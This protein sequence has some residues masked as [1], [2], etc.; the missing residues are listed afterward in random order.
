MSDADKELQGFKDLLSDPILGEKFIQMTSTPEGYYNMYGDTRGLGSF[1]VRL[2]QNFEPEDLA[3]RYTERLDSVQNARSELTSTIVQKV[4]SLDQKHVSYLQRALA[5]GPN[6]GDDRHLVPEPSSYL[7]EPTISEAL[8]K[9]TSNAEDAYGELLFW[10]KETDNFGPLLS[11][12]QISNDPRLADRF[13]HYYHTPIHYSDM[14]IG[15][16][17]ED[18]AMQDYERKQFLNAFDDYCKLESQREIV[19]QGKSSE[20]G[21]IV[22]L[23]LAVKSVLK[24]GEG[25]RK[26]EL[27]AQ[28]SHVRH[29]P[30]VELQLLKQLVDK[31]AI[32]KGDISVTP[33]SNSAG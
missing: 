6:G 18:D 23:V 7:S 30:A 14:Y 12:L 13:L 3:D 31:T 4:D 19:R 16:G 33:D 5:P 10:G 11:L 22:S 2:V 1:S 28:I 21:V 25:R 15:G 26:R 24:I 9:Y 20:T 17:Y 27:L 29:Q 32:N 8:K